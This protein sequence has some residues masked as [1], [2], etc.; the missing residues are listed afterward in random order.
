MKKISELTTEEAVD[1][2]CEMT[3]YVANISADEELLKVLREKLE[4]AAKASRAEIYTFGAA[5]ITKLVPILLKTHRNDVFGVLSVANGVPVEEIGKQN[6]ME[7]MKQVK[8]L[9]ADE[10]LLSFF[11]PSAKSAGEE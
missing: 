1:Y 7:T 4:G 10:E 8:E 6:I 5:K 9:C 2:L 3:P 11:K